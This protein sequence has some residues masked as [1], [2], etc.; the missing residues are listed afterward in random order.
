MTSVPPTP[1]ASACR[2]DAS[3]YAPAYGYPRG[4][5]QAP[6][7]YGPV[8][9]TAAYGGFGASGRRLRAAAVAPVPA[10]RRLHLAA[11][12]SAASPTLFPAPVVCML[13]AAGGPGPYG[14]P[15][16]TFGPG[17][18]IQKGRSASGPP[19]SNL[20]IFHIPNDVTNRD[21]AD[22]FAKFGNV[23]HASPVRTTATTRASGRCPAPP[24]ATCP[25]PRVT[26]PLPPPYACACA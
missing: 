16:P 26:L 3:D 24:P 20:F 25:C 4:G 23:S 7:G 5:Y 14:Q 12:L 13:C 11:A 10:G 18:P 15:A 17:M 2:A 1:A 22:M 6:I 19:G 9:Y 8:G 21:L